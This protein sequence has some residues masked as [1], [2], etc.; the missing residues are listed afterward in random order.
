M[1]PATSHNTH[2]T[3]DTHNTQISE[4][5]THKELTA[6]KGIYYGLVRRQQK[7]LAPGDQDLSPMHPPLMSCEW[8][9]AGTVLA[10]CCCCCGLLVGVGHPTRIAA[11]INRHSA[12]GLDLAPS[13]HN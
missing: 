11:G 6:L 10:V 8:G 1:V 9:A 13:A 5:G 3:L 2:N 12:T 4:A 7:G